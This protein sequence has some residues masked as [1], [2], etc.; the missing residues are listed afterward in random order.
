MTHETPPHPITDARRWSVLFPAERR[1]KLMGLLQR[2]RTLSVAD[3][4]G[5]LAVSQ[6][7]IR[8]DLVDLERFGRV[9]RSHG[10]ASLVGVGLGVEPPLLHRQ[11]EHQEE[12]R[13]I[14]LQSLELIQDGDAVA[15]DVGTTT[16]EVARAL[17]Q[18]RGLIIFTNS[19]PAAEV[20]SGSA[21]TVY[22]VGGQMRHQEYSLVGALARDTILRYRFDVF[23]LG[24]AGFDVDAGFSD[25][26]VEDVEIKRA[27]M[28]SANRTVALV[29]SSKWGRACLADVAPTRSVSA[30]VTDGAVSPSLAA[31]VRS[32]GVEVVVASRSQIQEASL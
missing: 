17:Q 12:K 24:V 5:H 29:D 30:I 11:D 19:I 15:L 23:F 3:L 9:V 28:A 10:G 14:A 25:Y 7:T 2:D 4:A 13:Q 32:Q 1:Q 21:H 18:R 31:Q 22:L 26:S 16:F 20:L 27:F 8:R 6:A